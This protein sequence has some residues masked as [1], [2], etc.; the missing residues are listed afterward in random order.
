MTLHNS[1]EDESQILDEEANLSVWFRTSAEEQKTGFIQGNTFDL[2]EVTYSSIN[3][4]AIFEGDI[5][6]GSV[7]DMEAFSKNVQISEFGVGISGNQFRWPN[8]LVPFEIDPTL[9]DQQRVTDAIQH[10]IGRTPIRFVQRTVANASQ[11]PNY[12]RFVDRNACFSQVGMRGGMQE[13]SLG[14]GCTTGAAIHEIGHAVGLWHEQSREDRE[15]F[16]RILWPN[17]KDQMQHNFNQHISDGDDIG[18]YD[19][20]SIMHYPT[21][22]FSKNGQPT[23]QAIGGESIG[24]RT[25]LSEGDIAAVRSM[26]L[27]K[28]SQAMWIHGTSLKVEYPDLIER[29]WN[30]GFYTEIEGKPN[31]ENWFHFAIPS[32]VIVNDQRLRIGSVML[33][34][35]TLSDDAVIRDVHIYDGPNKI[36]EHN[37]VDLSG[38]IGFSRF[39]APTVPF[40]QWGVGISVGVRFGET[41]SRIM[42]FKSAGC[43]FIS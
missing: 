13:I 25:G 23:I 7:E 40:V 35:E 43:D 34:S 21:H 27:T 19:F 36:A 24:Q 41:G 31:T 6:L 18:G 8:G 15:R 29:T 3:G 2:K 14:A 17:I 37:G 4:E 5:S 39:D 12:V 20:S 26:Y 22:A 33:L 1:L 16:V 38:N 10:W 28:L 32:K 30:A 11:F 9:A 42:R